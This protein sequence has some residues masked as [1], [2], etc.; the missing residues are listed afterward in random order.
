M[1]AV[2]IAP[3]NDAT[4]IPPSNKVTIENRPPTEAIR[5]T[6]TI[7][8]AEPMNANRGK[9]RVATV[10]APEAIAVTAPNAPPL[11]TPM[12]PG[13]A[14]ELRNN[15]CMIPPEIPNAAPTTK[16][17]KMR[18]KR[19]IWIIACSVGFAVDSPIPAR[20]SSVLAV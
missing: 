7:E 9:K 4:A 3:R 17:K 10:L 11:E 16:A 13:S 18:G 1:I 5:N 14:I 2:V 15:P 12:I 6:T 8:T 19:I 20:S